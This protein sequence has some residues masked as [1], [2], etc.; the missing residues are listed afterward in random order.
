MSSGFSFEEASSARVDDFE[1]GGGGEGGGSGSG[2]LKW[3]FMVQG[4]PA[5]GKS[6]DGRETVEEVS[7][8]D[9]EA[10]AA[11]SAADLDV[12]SEEGDREEA[13][14]SES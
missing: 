12:T 6:G 5:E 8:G 3:D 13:G 9:R 11:E 2:G 10:Q 7:E 4:Y 14:S 1:G